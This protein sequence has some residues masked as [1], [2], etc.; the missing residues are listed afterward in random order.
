M[1]EYKRFKYKNAPLVEVTFQV[2]YPVNLSIEANEPVEFQQ[3]VME[4]YPN[5]DSRTEY[6][7]EVTVNL[8]NEKANASASMS[9]HQRRKLHIFVSEDLKWKIT[10][11]K[12]MLALTTAEYRY[13]E[14]MEAKA[15]DVIDALIKAYKPMYFTRTGLRYIDAID[16]SSY[17]LE[18]EPWSELLKPHICGGLSYRTDGKVKIRSSS[19]SSEIQVDDLFINVASGTGMIDRHD[20]TMPHEAFILNCD[21]FY[22]RKCKVED[23]VDVSNRLHILSHKF[24]R[25]SITE[26]L[27]YS[28]EPE[29]LK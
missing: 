13:W 7:S 15:V 11:T 2:N 25:E 5:Y 24:F 8:E 27:H 3:L 4:K 28:M 21:Y 26:K 17:G 9:K 22:N 12:D 1:S 14:D 20:G 19:V 29:E 18:K 10:L 6:Q 23:L 16:R